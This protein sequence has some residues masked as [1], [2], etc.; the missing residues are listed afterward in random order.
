MSSSLLRFVDDVVCDDCVVA[1]CAG[2]GGGSAREERVE[3]SASRSSSVDA[4]VVAAFDSVLLS[5][6]LKARMSCFIL[7]D[8]FA[9][10]F[11]RRAF[12]RERRSRICFLIAFAGS[13]SSI[14]ATSASISST[15]SSA[16]STS[17][18]SAAA[19]STTGSATL[20]DLVEMIPFSGGGAN[21]NIVGS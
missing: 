14:A 2:D 9:R 10:G 15:S 16:S 4:V 5:V 13:E 11:G 6:L 21:P 1:S 12:V 17:S 8:S 18:S 3:N 19:S 20:L 7:P